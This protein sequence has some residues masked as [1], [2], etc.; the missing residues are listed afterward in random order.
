[1]HCH[2]CGKRQVEGARFC[3]DC[4]QQQHIQEDMHAGVSEIQKKPR[5]EFFYAV[6]KGK[7]ILL[8]ICTFGLY[9]LIWFGRNWNLIQQQE[10][11]K[12]SPVWRALFSVFFFYEFANK[13]LEVA[14]RKGYEHTFWPG[15]LTVAYI[16]FV[17]ASRFPEGWSLISLLSFLPF[18]PLLDAIFFVNEHVPNAKVDQHVHIIEVVAVIV[19][20]VL[21]LF[22][23]FGLLT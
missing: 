23:L 10:K 21:I 5:P 6:S 18:I 3:K 20:G 19:G 16:F 4:G 8:S 13:V 1:M 7:F 17:L 22:A 14:K 2:K 12:I 9:E 11:T 15:G